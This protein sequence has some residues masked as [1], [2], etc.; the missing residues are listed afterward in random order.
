MN[1]E[2]HLLCHEHVNFV[3]I[4]IQGIFK[5]LSDS[6]VIVLFFIFVILALL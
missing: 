4:I 2:L 6:Y 3:Q 1:L 5:L